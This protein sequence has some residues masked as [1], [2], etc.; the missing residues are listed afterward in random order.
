MNDL[1]AVDEVFSHHI[2]SSVADIYGHK[3][4]VIVSVT[5]THSGRV[6]TLN[7][8]ISLFNI[9]YGVFSG[10]DDCYVDYIVRQTKQMINGSVDMLEECLFNY[11]MVAFMNG[12]AGEIYSSLLGLDHML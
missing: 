11:D 8:F 9:I 12:A 1:I 4:K 3:P 5:H 6:G 7:T 10:W 2:H